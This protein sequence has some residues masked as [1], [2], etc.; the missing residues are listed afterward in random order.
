MTQVIVVDDEQTV[1]LNLVAY[2]EDEGFDILSA[3][4]AEHA[5][6]LISDKKPD[7]G[8]IDLRLPGMN[9]N[10]LIIKAHEMLPSMKFVIHTGSTDYIL[11][12]NLK[13]IGINEKQVIHK[14]VS[15]MQ[16]LS[17]EISKL[18]KA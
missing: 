5:L 18:I 15:D 9:G 8:I 4:D 10:E 3:R 6:K 16:I 13:A 2:L 11:P 14:P 7:V 1:L 12:D 17:N